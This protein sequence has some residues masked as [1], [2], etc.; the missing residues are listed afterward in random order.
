[1]DNFSRTFRLC[2]A[3]VI[4]GLGHPSFLYAA[5]PSLWKRD[6]LSGDWGGTRD[7]WSQRGLDFTFEYTGELIGT[8]GGI[9]SGSVY[10]GLGYGGI[11]IDAQKAFGWNGTTLH[12]STLWTHGSSPGQYTGDELGVSNIDAYD[13]LRLLQVFA[14]KDFGKLNL[15][16]GNLLADEEFI[17]D[18][19]SDTFVNDSFGQPA[20]WSANT[21]NGGPAFYA[22]GLGLRLRYDF[23]EAAYIQAG[24]YDG[25]TVDDA[26]GDPSINQHGL[27]FELGNG[28][29]WTSLYEIGYNGFNVDDN[30]GLPGWYRAGAW[31]HSA[32]FEKHAGGKSE[33]NGGIYAAMDQMVVREKGDQGL[34]V[35]WCLGVSEHDRS[36]FQWSLDAGASYQGLFSG[37]DEDTAAIGLI[38]G[39]HSREASSPR[40]HERVLELTYKYQL[41]P[42]VYLQPDI[43]WINRP[44]GDSSIG[45]AWAFGLRVGMEF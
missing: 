17:G 12:M 41:S 2:G 34:G 24:I 31:H 4:L 21:L 6:Q 38:Y 20:A 42:S 35:Y 29:G 28:Q 3:V 9:S 30:T 44:G 25:D 18:H 16:I 23:S 33:G 19:Y 32:E 11:D 40:S 13:G 39:R 22:P 43:Q 10:Q 37:R 27:H 7:S 1:M 14:E 26:A 15:R 45:D 5:T 8:S 36:R